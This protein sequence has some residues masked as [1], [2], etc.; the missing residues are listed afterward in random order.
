VRIV[1]SLLDF[2]EWKE[3]MP[4]LI[5]GTMGRQRRGRW[6]TTVANAWGV[7]ALKKFSKKFEAVPVKGVSTAIFIGVEKEVRWKA[8]PGGETLM[9]GWNEGENELTFTH[10]D[11]G[12]PWIT[13]QSLAAIPLKEPL[14]SGYKII[15][16]LIPVDRKHEEKWSRGDVIRVRLELEAQ[17]DMTWVVVKDP[18]PAG[19]S[20]LGT[21]LGRDSR[22]LTSGE[23]QKGW[24]WPVF[25]ERSFEEFRAY[26]DYV[27]KGKWTVE[28]TIR[29]N[30]E[31][32]F[33]LPETRVEALYSPEMFGEIPNGEFEVH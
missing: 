16:T 24:A 11:E 22:I 12:R 5:K 2:K 25:Q 6:S 4:R 18:I 33:H 13:L 20:I 17:A 29:L 31:G 15:R 21:G 8:S 14:S 28:Y 26:F 23:R 9:F 32:V 19:S 10:Q 27:P 7:V 30:N 1:L 3:D